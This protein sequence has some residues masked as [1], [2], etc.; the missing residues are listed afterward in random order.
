ME[1]IGLSRLT[2]LTSLDV[3]GALISDES[4]INY[5]PR[6]LRKL[7]LFSFKYSN[8]IISSNALA[9]LPEQLNFLDLTGPFE[10]DKSYQHFP[11]TLS[12]LR[13]KECEFQ[14]PV[15][16]FPPDLRTLELH[17]IPGDLTQFLKN[18]PTKYSVA[19]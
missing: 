8:I 12:F 9:R 5:L 7:W 15:F 1:K 13:L 11:T 17:S 14:G 10:L 18:L 19:L 16:I 4:I 6:S 3:S 2:N